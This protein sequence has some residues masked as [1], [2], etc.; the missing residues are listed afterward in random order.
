MKRTIQEECTQFTDSAY[1]VNGSEYYAIDVVVEY[2]DELDSLED[3]ELEKLADATFLGD[4]TDG[5][6]VHYL[7]DSN[8]QI[9]TGHYQYP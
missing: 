3:W 2:P 8:G 4:I 6:G 7:G 5:K 1:W 9:T